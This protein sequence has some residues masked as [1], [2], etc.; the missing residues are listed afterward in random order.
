MRGRYIYATESCAQ[1]GGYGG[2]HA[3][4]VTCVEAQ[5]GVGEEVRCRL[6]EGTRATGGSGHELG[7]CGRAGSFQAEGLVEREAPTAALGVMQI[8]ASQF[9]GTEEGVDSANAIT[10]N[11]FE[12]CGRLAVG[13][14]LTV[15]VEFGY[16]PLAVAQQGFAQTGLDPFG[17]FAQSGRS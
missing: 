7:N 16:D 5:S 9:K 2:D 15:V 3:S 8:V 1:F 11:A 6:L 12:C 10:V 4:Q 13:Q 14:Q 17:T